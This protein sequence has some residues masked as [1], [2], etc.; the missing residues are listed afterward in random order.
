MNRQSYLLSKIA[1]EAAEVAVEALKAQQFGLEDRFQ[2][3][4]SNAERLAAE[5]SDLLTVIGVLSAEF[6]F[7]STVT[8][9]Q[10]NPGKVDKVDHYYH[11]TVLGGIDILGTLERM[12]KL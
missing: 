11:Q 2:N 8:I 5:V 9:N 4:P 12:S 3:G 7:E 6:G 1:E 10:V